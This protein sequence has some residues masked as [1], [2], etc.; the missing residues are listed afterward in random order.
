MPDLTV[1]EITL[2]APCRA[3]AANCR[4]IVPVSALLPQPAAALAK[5]AAAAGDIVELRLDALADQSPA[6]LA[7]AVQTVRRA[8]GDTPLL[9]TLR[10][11]GEGGAATLDP[12]AYANTLR[13]LCAAA[14]ADIDLLDVEFAI[15]AAACARLRAAAHEAGAAVVFSAHNFA[16]TPDTGAMTGLL[17]AMADAGAD[18]AKLAVMPADAADAARLLEATARAA[19]LRPE[20]P[21]LTMAM[22]APGAVTRVCG[23]AFGVCASFG[24]AGAASAPGQP[25]AASLRRA[26]SALRDCGGGQG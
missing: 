4:V 3:R 9:V 11:Q 7:W 25:D 19:A 14:G 5:T 26:L 24:T 20:T 1:R 22:G 21:L 15:G 23:A 13:A 18:V 2:A 6:G 17:T 8:I 16:E 10:T 12:A